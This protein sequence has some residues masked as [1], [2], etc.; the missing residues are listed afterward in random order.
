[1][2]DRVEEG[3]ILS[4]RYVVSVG[5]VHDRNVVESV[6]QPIRETTE[7]RVDEVRRLYGLLVKKN[8]AL[9]ILGKM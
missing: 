9:I 7:E 4:R 8:S 3:K 1:M 5:Y 6:D 2:E